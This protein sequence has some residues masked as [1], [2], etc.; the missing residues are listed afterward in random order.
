[1]I[2]AMRH[3][4][5]AQNVLQVSLHGLVFRLDCPPEIHTSIAARL[6]DFAPAPGKHAD[7]TVI[8][9]SERPLHV[10][11][12]DGRLV[13]E[14][15]LGTL[16]YSPEEDALYAF[17]GESASMRC[18]AALAHAEICFDRPDRDTAWI[19]T[20][21]LLTIAV[22]ELLRRR[23]LYPLHAACLASRD[24][25]VLICGPSG[26]G[27]SSLTLALL[28]A[29][30]DF[31]GDDLVFVRETDAGVRAF[32]FPDE[33]GLSADVA[34]LGVRIPSAV[35]LLPQP[36][37]PKARVGVHSVSPTAT[38]VSSCTPRLIVILAEGADPGVIV[39][40]TPDAALLDL[41]PSI[42]LTEPS[43]CAAHLAALASLAGSATLLRVGARPDLAAVTGLIMR[44]LSRLNSS[45]GER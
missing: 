15:S 27:K 26:S 8:Y 42:L 9:D 36:G 12:R 16:I 13:Y 38:V 14:S 3:G 2:S 7:L 35:D 34:E 24:S 45:Q 44:T 19:L 18:A 6:A 43:T 23:D 4:S 20:R 5:S 30:L 31:L 39:E 21:P 1:M 22:M 11:P 28:G 29:G 32:G 33:L 40:S 17:Y 25:G 10:R 41:V 37:W